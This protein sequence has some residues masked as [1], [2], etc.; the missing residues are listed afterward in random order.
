[1]L[2]ELFRT[3]G[4]PTYIQIQ[5]AL[6][7]H[8]L[9]VSIRTI[10]Q[11]IAYFE[12]HY[13]AKF[14]TGL[15]SGHST[16]VRYHDITKS[17][18]DKSDIV[19]KLFDVSRKIQADNDLYPHYVLASTMIQHLLNGNPINEFYKAVD[20]GSNIDLTGI[21]FFGDILKSIINKQCVSFLY[22]PANKETI[23]P[24]VSP[25]QLRQYNQRWYLFC[26]TIGSDVYSIDALDR[27]EGDI[28]ESSAEYEEPDWKR[29]SGLDDTIG[30]FDALNEK[31]Q[32]DDILLRVS[33]KR[34][35]FIESKPIHRSQEH[36]EAEDD[37]EIIK[38]HVK[39]NRELISTILYYGDDIEVLKP[40]NLR[41][42][43]TLIY[44]LMASKYTKT[45]K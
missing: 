21:E 16:V 33:K 4:G 15:R 36:I 27:I 37:S 41:R 18:L 19:D 39:I 24:T 40:D 8:N 1:M 42:D 22:K 25:Y 44:S 26:K 2:D 28:T 7:E 43:I 23:H 30:T 12:S 32:P 11:D 9:S 5:E 29:L 20:F 38:I 34:Y 17:V 13:K 14:K 45:T 10:Q 3:P 31:V 35:P 6:S